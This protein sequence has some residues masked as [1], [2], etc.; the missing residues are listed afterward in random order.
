NGTA[1]AAMP[2]LGNGNYSF[3]VNDVT[4]AFT[5]SLVT[6]TFSGRYPGI[7]ANQTVRGLPAKVEYF[8][9][10]TSSGAPPAEH[11]P[12]FAPVGANMRLSF[13]RRTDDSTLNHVVEFRGDLASGN[14][15][16]VSATPVPQSAGTGLERLT[17][18]IPTY[19]A[20]KGFYRIRV[21]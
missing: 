18:D 13:V 14:W 20:S 15:Q 9:G 12:T 3:E 4:R 19:G 16:P 8:L 21:W 7:S 6:N 2:N 5:V 17:Y 1:N 11:L 10:G